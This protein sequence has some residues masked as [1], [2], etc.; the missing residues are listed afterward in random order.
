MSPSQPQDRRKG[1]AL[2]GQSVQYRLRSS[3][4]RPLL[5]AGRLR[6][7]KGAPIVGSAGEFR[8]QVARRPHSGAG[9]TEAAACLIGAR[10]ESPPRS[11]AAENRVQP[12]WQFDRPS[13]LRGTRSGQPRGHHRGVTEPVS[14]PMEPGCVVK[15]RPGSLTASTPPSFGAP[16]HRANGLRSRGQGASAG[17]PPAG[18]RP[19][20]AR[21][22]AFSPNL[23]ARLHVS[24]CDLR[25]GGPAE[26]ERPEP[27]RVT[28]GC[29][30]N[31]PVG[32]GSLRPRL[33]HPRRPRG[34]PAAASVDQRAR[35]DL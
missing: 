16:P 7:A 3:A 21:A 24:I 29:V 4:A 10:N 11:V 9:A 27:Y 15:L 35:A 30:S 17:R 18:R 19:L 14:R 33:S 6:P 25:L 26:C 22:R 23:R 1:A 31:G 28:S 8:W 12:R 20:P 5:V 32:V 2:V 13:T 34:P